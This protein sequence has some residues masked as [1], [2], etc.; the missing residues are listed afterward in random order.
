MKRIKGLDG[1]RGIAILLVLIFHFVSSSLSPEFGNKGASNF[2]ATSLIKL[3]SSFWCG[4]DL[5]FVLSG[6][7]IGSIILKN[8]GQINFFST[9]YLKRFYRIIP[10]Y[11]ALILIFIIAKFFFHKYDNK[12]LFEN[13]IPAYYYLTFTQNFI[14]GI[15]NNFGPSGLNPTW[16]LAVEEQF[17]I[18]FPLVALFFR[19]RYLL[20]VVFML[21]VLAP[22]FRESM[23]NFYQKYTLI[24]CRMDSLLL[25]VLVAYFWNKQTFKSKIINNKKI[26]WLFFLA[27]LIATFLGALFD[28]GY[29]GFT[30][31]A[32]TFSFLI[33]LCLVDPNNIFIKLIANKIFVFFGSI[34]YSLYLIHH[35]ILGL[36]FLLFK[37]TGPSINDWNG[38]F[39]AFLAL[40]VSV[41]YAYFST[42]Y[43]ELFFIKKGVNLKYN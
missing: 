11:F 28:I 38:V 41:I 36:L 18:I 37:G 27:S 8:I 1:L 22:I 26:I 34:S 32:I 39:I 30:I 19:K 40:I 35:L 14:M 43:F 15:R 12:W 7:L 33:L 17:Y 10:A 6:F 5:F 9:F 24:I 4:V 21:I 16:S 29:W 25:G 23:S 42:N 31:S 3:T 2:I 13:D 20:Y